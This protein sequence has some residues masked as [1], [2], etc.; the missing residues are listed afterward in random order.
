MAAR[1]ALERLDMAF[2]QIPDVHSET[3]EV[4]AWSTDVHVSLKFPDQ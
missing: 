3:F 1:Q 2:R 4:D